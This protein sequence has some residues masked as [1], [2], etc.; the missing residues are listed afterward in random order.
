MHTHH[1]HA[2][3]LLY[4]PSHLHSFIHTHPHSHS[5]HTSTPHIFTLRYAHIGMST[6]MHPHY[7]CKLTYNPH[8]PHAY[9]YSHVDSYTYVDICIP[10]HSHAP[11]HTHMCTTHT[12]TRILTCM[13]TTDTIHSC[14]H[15]RTHSRAPSEWHDARATSLS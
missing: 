14:T 2:A 13:H 8:P 10:T 5:P 4:A 6:N 7:V 9:V 11:T 15:T 1:R 12:P 3:L